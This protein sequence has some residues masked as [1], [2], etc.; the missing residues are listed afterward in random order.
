MYL[1][2]PIRLLVLTIVTFVSA[3]TFGQQL[4]PDA[5]AKGIDQKNVQLLDVRTAEEYKSG[6]IPHALQANWKNQSEFLNRIQ[7]I[8]K[9][10]SVYVYCAAGSRSKEAA[11]WL[12]TN[13]YTNVYELTGGFIKWKAENK[14]VEGM[15]D[16]K[17]MTR[18]A[19]NAELSANGITLVDVG[20]DWCA[21]CRK[22]EPVLQSLQRD[23]AG[24]FKLV[25]IDA[26]I[27]TDLIKQLQA[28]D[29]PTFIVYQNGKEVWRKTGVID[30]EELKKAINR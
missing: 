12:R 11:E 20:A 13:G 26:G 30:M 8:D 4:A 16:I 14:A 24:K 10:K 21:P 15:P 1:N 29:I 6:H 18:E 25:K 5:F 9:T 19:F 7:Y 28:T 22:M 3:T 27:H 23:M 2:N 17:P